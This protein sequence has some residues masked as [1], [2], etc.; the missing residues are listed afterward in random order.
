MTALQ[1]L[2]SPEFGCCTTSEL[3][4]LARTNKDDVA[5][6]KVWAA[7]EMKKKEIPITENK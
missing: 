5:K 1:F 4:A 7:E 2:T 3:M 6:L